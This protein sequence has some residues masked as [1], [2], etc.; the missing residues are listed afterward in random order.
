[1]NEDTD[2]QFIEGAQAQRLNAEIKR[3][4]AEKR[5]AALSTAKMEAEQ[6]GKQ[7]F[8]LELL[9]NLC[10]TSH[11]T[12]ERFEMIYYVEHPDVMT[13]AELA[14]IINKLNFWDYGH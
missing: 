10:D 6:R 3:N 2:H 12:P 1:M 14:E 9:S 13:L 4:N 5:A 11:E 7:P 8:N